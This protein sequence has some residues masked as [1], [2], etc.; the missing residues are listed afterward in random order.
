MQVTGIDHVVFN[1]ADGERAVAW[2]RDELGLE[3]ERLQEWRRGDVLFPSVR[4]SAD[5]IVDLLVGPRS[6]ENVNHVAIVVTEVDLDDLAASGRFD[7]VSGPSD[8][9]GARGVGRGL[10]VRDPDGNVVELRTYA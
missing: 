6:G 1:V 3:P 9:F 8:L 10:Y 2:W 7:V 5:T 4:I